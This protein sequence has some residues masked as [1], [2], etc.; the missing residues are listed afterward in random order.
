MPLHL[1]LS[2]P[3]VKIDAAIPVPEWGLSDLGRNRT[4]AMAG[5]SWIR[6]F[7][8]VV[9]STETKAIETA[10]IL[11]AALGVPVDIR[12]SLHENDRSA[13]GFLN[14]PEFEATADQFF[15]HP[16]DNIRGWERAVDVQA[17]ITGAVLRALS[18]APDTPT[19]FVGHGG[20][21]T[22]LQCHC[23]RRS[24]A[25][26]SDQPAGGGNHYLFDIE[27]RIVLYGWRPMEMQPETL[28]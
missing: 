20:V 5:Q 27:K 16:E 28:P 7:H 25:R 19:I 17:R 1:Y 21:G 11:A 14:P 3:Q 22:L 26:T 4:E 24:I 15:K 2:H 6:A 13:T 18:E 10:E 12:Q 8:R 9:S 23:A